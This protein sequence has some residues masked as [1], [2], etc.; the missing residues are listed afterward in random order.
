MIK[1]PFERIFLTHWLERISDFFEPCSAMHPA[2]GK[3]RPRSIILLCFLF[4]SLFGACGL[5]EKESQPVQSH[6]AEPSQSAVSVELK[7]LSI[8]PEH[9]AAMEQSIGMFEKANPGITIQ[10]KL[11][12]WDKVYDVLQTSIQSNNPPDISFMWSSAMVDWVKLDVALNLTPY[13]SDAISQTIRYGIYEQGIHDGKLYAL[14][15][16]QTFSVL[17]Y[18]DDLFS[19]FK[20]TAPVTI[21]QFEVLSDSL[22]KQGITPLVVWGLPSNGLPVDSV[23][24]DIAFNMNKS[25]ELSNRAIPMTDR[26]Y[27]D[28]YDRMASWYGKGYINANYAE[29]TREDTQEL[30]RNGKVAM[31][32][33][34]IN[35]YYT[36]ARNIGFKVKAVPFPTL[37]KDEKPKM[38]IGSDGFFVLATTLHPTASTDFL[39]FLITPSIQQLW[40]EDTFSMPVING[41]MTSD[42]AFESIMRDSDQY[43]WTWN[44]GKNAPSSRELVDAVN[45]NQVYFIMGLK[46]YA[47]MADQFEKLRKQVIDDPAKK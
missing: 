16:R 41:L 34:N 13:M 32:V 23:Y 9:T 39:K 18:N 4:V 20:L 8:W 47:D 26:I 5:S 28:A 3:S 21:R 25:E 11:T 35:E 40:M 38:L 44:E 42:A 36:L 14:P 43:R 1:S 46:K 37:A 2:K 27:S 7:L 33:G 15:F 17:F 22:K 6:A 10:Q 29:A 12:T 24:T 30:F 19:A 45:R 31:M